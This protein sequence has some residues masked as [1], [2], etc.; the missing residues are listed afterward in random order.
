MVPQVL[1]LR[2]EN[3][4]AEN[5]GGGELRFPGPVGN[6][7]RSLGMGSV[8]GGLR[9]MQAKSLLYIKAVV[10]LFGAGE[11]LPIQK[12][13]LAADWAENIGNA[14]RWFA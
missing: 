1:E 14:V 5:G 6:I 3:C 8:R 13:T 12:K 9:V 4:P 11:A 2:L 7:E 10:V